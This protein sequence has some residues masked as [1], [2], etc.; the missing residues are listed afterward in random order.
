MK[1]KLKLNMS[2]KKVFF[3]GFLMGLVPAFIWQFY[4]DFSLSF[5]S[6][7]PALFLGFVAVFLRFIYSK[8][9]IIGFIFLII[10]IIIY[11]WLIVLVINDTFFVK[12]WI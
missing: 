5:Y 3:I 12:S 4:L 6:I 7:I 2:S 1:N 10:L 9:R 11:L 8:N